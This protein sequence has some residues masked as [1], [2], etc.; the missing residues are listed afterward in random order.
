MGRR[1]LVILTLTLLVACGLTPRTPGPPPQAP[2]PEFS[3]PS[4]TGES[5]TLA[6]LTANGPAVVVFYRG[7]W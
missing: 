2:A 1:L 7:F 3:L 4:H 5:V 6:Q